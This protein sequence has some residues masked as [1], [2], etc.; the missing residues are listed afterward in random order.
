MRGR[1]REAR[2]R[3]KRSGRRAGRA[4]PLRSKTPTRCSLIP[5]PD[6]CTFFLCRPAWCEP[7]STEGA[8]GALQGHGVRKLLSFQVLVCLFSGGRGAGGGG[9]ALPKLSLLPAGYVMHQ[10]SPPL[11]ESFFTT[12]NAVFLRQLATLQR[13]PNLI[14]LGWRGFLWVLSFSLF[15]PPWSRGSACFSAFATSDSSASS[16]RPLSGLPSF[17][18]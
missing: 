6:L 3:G 8:R 11:L 15:T 4:W 5:Q 16:S 9:F 2:R 7:L 17:P 18:S 13:G 14:S 1:E 10:L 12:L